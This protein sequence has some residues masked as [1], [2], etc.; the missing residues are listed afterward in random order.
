M[1]RHF[2]CFLALAAGAASA[3]DSGFLLL[4]REEAGRVKAAI[5]RKDP[6]L[7]PAAAALRKAADKALSA[8]PWSVTFHRPANVP[9]A[10][11][12][13]YSEGPYWWPDPKNPAGPYIRRDG[14]TNPDRFMGNREDIAT[15]G[16]AVLT[17]G[18]AAWLFDEPRYSRR[19]REVLAVW[20]VR[21]ET[22]MN[23]HLEFA[24]AVRGHNYGRG[25]GIIDTRPLIWTVQG[26]TFLQNSAGWDRA[27]GAE[28]RKWF[29]AYTEWLTTSAKGKD[30]K[31]AGNNHCTWWAVQLAA[32]AS[33]TGD[34][35]QPGNGL[36]PLPRS[37]GAQ[38]VPPGRRRPAR[39]GAHPVAE[40]FRHEPGRLHHHVPHGRGRRARTCGASARAKRAGVE[41]AV[42]YLA[43][44]VMQPGTWKLPQIRPHEPEQNYFLGLAAMAYGK[45]EYAAVQLGYPRGQ[46]T[47]S[48]FLEMLL[49]TKP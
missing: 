25:A 1:T 5:A 38:P 17:L 27:L 19:A 13:Y 44:F 18:A 33:F 23:P 36:E 31:K 3:A 8:G 43:P 12:D 49:R 21:P 34:R 47:W 9:A 16:E 32:Y 10:K 7:A 46:R 15:M 39:R 4:S 42:A 28:L 20:F 11:N 48:L 26:I 41:Q 24:Q 45:P 40:L 22:R 37:P 6:A 2:F 35:A 30:E 29:A 14:E